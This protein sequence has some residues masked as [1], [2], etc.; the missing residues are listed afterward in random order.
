[1]KK[2]LLLL[3]IACAPLSSQ[4]LAQQW[5]GAIKLGTASTTFHGDL[6]AGE[7]VWSRRLGISAGTA[8]GLKLPYGFTPSVELLY[9]RMGASTP[10]I[11]L[12]IPATLQSDLT[13]LMATLLLQYRLH[14]GRYVY[15]RI[16]AGPTYAHQI[17]AVVSVTARDGLGV[18][19]E[20]DD[21]VEKVDYGFTIGGALDME[22]GSQV[23]T[24]ELRYYLGQRD[25]TKPNPELGESELRNAGVTVMAG[26]VF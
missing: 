25:I 13:Y 16:F 8:V 5:E 10:V 22:I 26:L 15:P 11:F 2:L 18:I 17:G 7:T 23:A 3:I 21:S 24:L 1:M 14:T 20:Q 12:D 6:A 4:A 9:A 19:V